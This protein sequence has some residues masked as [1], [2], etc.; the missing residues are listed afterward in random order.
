MLAAI[1][2]TN[3]MRF[4]NVVLGSRATHTGDSVVTNRLDL[5]GNTYA[6]VPGLATTNGLPPTRI[7]LRGATIYSTSRGSWGA[8]SAN[9]TL[10]EGSR[11]AVC[12]TALSKGIGAAISGEGIAE[13]TWLKAAITEYSLELSQPATKSGTFSLQVEGAPSGLAS[14]QSVREL[15]LE[16]S[17]SLNLSNYQSSSNRWEVGELTGR[18]ALTKAGDGLLAVGVGSGFTGSV[19]V[20]GPVEIK[21]TDAAHQ[22]LDGLH[23]ENGSVALPD[24]DMTL[25]IG[26]LSGSGTAVKTGPGTL[27]VAAVSD[28]E[29]F[30]EMIVQEG[31]VAL[32]GGNG[33]CS[34]CPVPGAWFHVDAS[35]ADTLTTVE[36]NGTNFVT[37]WNDADGGSVY[38]TAGTRPF[39]NTNAL[40]GR[41]TIDF[42]S[43]H[44]PS[45][46][47]TGYGG[48]MDWSAADTAIREV[49]IVCSDTEDIADLPEDLTGNFLLG[50]SARAWNFHRGFN[51]SLFI[52]YTAAEIRNGLIEMDGA[53]CAMDAP[54][55]DGFHLVHLRT[56]GNVRANAF[57]RNRALAYGGQ[58]I[59][60]MAVYNRTL[61]DEE[62]RLATLGLL[63]KWLGAGVPAVRAFETLRVAENAV[64]DLS[65]MAVSASNLLCRG[66]IRAASLAPEA[67][68]LTSDGVGLTG[69][70]LDG[71]LAAGTPG[72]I[73][74]DGAVLPQVAGA[75]F[76]FA[77]VDGV[78]DVSAL[79]RW[80]VEGSAL[81]A[82]WS[83]RL[84]LLDG[85]RLAVRLSASGFIIMVR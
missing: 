77:T 80:S 66:T 79:A 45:L 74:L 71:R 36:E 51:R 67:I 59:A 18:G 63:G 78:D 28:G 68:R 58:R 39:V 15:A 46:G 43:Y 40:D 14:V 13:G 75:T 22:P 53:T 81:S 26:T 34:A 30:T 82:G 20:A 70:T 29:A 42:G 23:I 19:S 54:L 9:F 4:S 55:P 69:F 41:A 50:E 84:V 35:R 11:M 12:A 72:R 44:Y 65:G 62:A 85:N 16:G 33:I 6:D 73:V 83:G 60:E 38:A 61:T 57:A 64:L 10:T 24:A 25:A 3:T 31:T 52:S 8:F 5:Y 49:F 32:G 2:G 27:A 76:A 21:K 1:E 47:V 7:T 56:T 37:R 48:Y 17:G